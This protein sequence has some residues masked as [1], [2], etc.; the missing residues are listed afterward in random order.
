MRYLKKFN[1]SV[2]VP[3][4]FRYSLEILE[5]TEISTL[6]DV[7]NIFTAD[8]IEFVNVDYFKSKLQTKK[9]IELVPVKLE[10]FGGVKFAA[11]NYYTNQIY[12]CVNEPVF[13]RSMTDSSIKKK[14][15]DFLFEVLR[16]ESIHRQQHS[17]RSI[18]KKNLERSPVDPKPYFGDYDEVMAYA[19]SFIDQCHQQGLTDSEI[20]DIIRHNRKVSWIQNAYDL[21]DPNSRKKFYKYVYQYLNNQQ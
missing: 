5:N 2:I 13:L 19:Q 17:R 7:N 21:V 8:G 3:D 16:H 12:V 11:F 10:L 14:L 1:E 9:E 20:L 18:L 4:D 15:I 6:N